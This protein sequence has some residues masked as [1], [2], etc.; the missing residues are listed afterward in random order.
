MKKV[1]VGCIKMMMKKKFNNNIQKILKINYESLQKY[2]VTC[3]YGVEYKTDLRGT[4]GEIH[5]TL[6]MLSKCCCWV[7]YNH[8]C[9]EPRN[10]KVHHCGHTCSLFTKE[11][12]CKR[13]KHEN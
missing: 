4:D 6:D 5:R 3:R 7:C 10:E 12:Y 11:P 8:D 2:P 13:E 1:K 9:K